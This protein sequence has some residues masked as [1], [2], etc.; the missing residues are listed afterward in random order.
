MFMTSADIMPSSSQLETPDVVT[1]LVQRA[2]QHRGFFRLCLHLHAMFVHNILVTADHMVTCAFV[3][4]RAWL[5]GGF[6]VW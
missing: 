1:T 6:Q 5:K 4:H 3:L 2:A